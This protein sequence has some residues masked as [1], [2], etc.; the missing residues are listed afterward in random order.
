M[1][2]GIIFA[3][4]LM[5][6]ACATN[7]PIASDYDMPLNCVARRGC[8]SHHGGVAGCVKS[9]LRCRDGSFSPTCVCN[10]IDDLQEI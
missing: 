5:L 8:C 2:W 4:V 9:R 1:K 10:G 3:F 6:S 7:Q